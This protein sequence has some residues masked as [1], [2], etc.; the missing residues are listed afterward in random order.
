MAGSGL[1]EVMECCY[2]RNT[3]IQTLAGKAVK[4]AVRHGGTG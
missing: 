1:T 3:V 4:R 2:G